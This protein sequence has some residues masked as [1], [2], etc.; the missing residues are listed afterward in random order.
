MG[1]THLSS[2]PPSAAPTPPHEWGGQNKK[3]G[4]HRTPARN[5]LTK[6]LK[7]SVLLLLR[8]LL[9]CLLCRLLRGLLLRCHHALPP[10]PKDVDPIGSIRFRR[11][12]LIDEDSETLAVSRNGRLSRAGSVASVVATTSSIAIQSA[13][14]LDEPHSRQCFA[15]NFLRDLWINSADVASY[16]DHQRCLLLISQDCDDSD[17]ESRP[18]SWRIGQRRIDEALR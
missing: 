10:S 3:P 8:G 9:R 2:A 17:D 4:L 6:R 1:R 5:G 11:E 15:R 12:P 13:L 14:I 16:L 18:R 7:R